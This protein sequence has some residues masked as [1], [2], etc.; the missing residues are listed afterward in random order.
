[1]QADLIP[2]FIDINIK[3]LQF[4]ENDL[5]NLPKKVINNLAC[6]IIPSPMGMPIS[7]NKLKKIKKKY[8]CELI[9]DAADTFNNLSKN[10]DKINLFTTISFHNNKNLVS[11]ESGLII[12]KKKK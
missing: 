7:I 6:I 2:F 4:D 11:N 12:C 8:K 9:Y 1:M 10:L 3:N 5:L